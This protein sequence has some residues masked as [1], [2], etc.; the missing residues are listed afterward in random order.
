L[1]KSIDPSIDS[2]MVVLP[3]ETGGMV[4]VETSVRSASLI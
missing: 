1:K 3:P 2:D 4:Q